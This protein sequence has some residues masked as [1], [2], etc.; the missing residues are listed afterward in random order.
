MKTLIAK[1]ARAP[2]HPEVAPSNPQRTVHGINQHNID[3]MEARLAREK[4]RPTDGFND[5]SL[6]EHSD[7]VRAL[8]SRV[9]RAKQTLRSK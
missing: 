1:T 9:A 4:N 5:V 8:E 7:K 6:K 3:E 2:R